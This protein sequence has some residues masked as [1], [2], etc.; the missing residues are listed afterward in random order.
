MC[1]SVFKPALNQPRWLTQANHVLW[2]TEALNTMDRCQPPL[3]ALQGHYCTTRWII[4]RKYNFGV[5]FLKQKPLC[6]SCGQIV[7]NRKEITPV[8]ILLLV[9]SCSWAWTKMGSF[10]WNKIFVFTSRPWSMY[11]LFLQDGIIASQLDASDY[12]LLRSN[13]NSLAASTAHAV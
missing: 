12:T 2:F 3:T 11:K 1:L 5:G 13:E 6:I 9:M 10:N 7:L 4:S 8:S